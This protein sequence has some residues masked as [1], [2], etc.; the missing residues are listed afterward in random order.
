MLS[1]V[2]AIN[3]SVTCKNHLSCWSVQYS[4]VCYLVVDDNLKMHK[5][6]LQRTLA[7]MQQV[8]PT[9]NLGHGDKELYWLAA[10]A[11]GDP[12][13]WEPFVAGAYGAALYN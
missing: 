8:L 5:G 10:T 11:A 12:V 13:A 1:T 9:F 6:K 7:L 3:L 2:H 4:I